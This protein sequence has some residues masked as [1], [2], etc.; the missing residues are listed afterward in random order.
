MHRPS[1]LK[2]AH[3]SR[4]RDELDAEMNVLFQTTDWLPGMAGLTVGSWRRLSGAKSVIA[5][6]RSPCGL[7]KQNSRDNERLRGL[8]ESRLDIGAVQSRR[9]ATEPCPQR[10]IASDCTRC[11]D[12]PVHC[13]VPT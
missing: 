1:Q 7:H 10:E 8:C 5:A 4:L 6:P 9:C 12:E 13:V 11:T 2:S 3:L